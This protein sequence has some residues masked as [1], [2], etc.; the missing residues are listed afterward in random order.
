MGP[1]TRYAIRVYERTHGLPADGV[2][3]RRLLATMGIA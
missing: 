1:R 3:D 2:I